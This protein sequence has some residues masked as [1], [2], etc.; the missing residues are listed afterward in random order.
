MDDILQKSLLYDFYGEL[1]T[2]H[3]RKIYEEFNFDDLSLGEISE[4]EGISRQAVHDSIRKTD[5]ALTEYEEKL[6]L[7]S[8][9]EAIRS[10]A[11]QILELASCEDGADADGDESRLQ[12]IK[13][14]CQE[15]L[16]DL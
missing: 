16:G 6:H 2:T 7:V 15:I 8:R 4:I 13:T 3:Q 11:E 12:A 5:R 9:F 10:R 1:L 14:L